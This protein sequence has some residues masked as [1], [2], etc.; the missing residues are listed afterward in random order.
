[1]AKSNS[2]KKKTPKRVLALPDLEHATTAAPRVLR[3]YAMLAVLIGRGLRR[4]ELLA[5]QL[6]AIQQREDHWVIA[7]L[8]GKAGHIRTVPIPTWVKTT[9]DAWTT[10]ADISEGTVF[11]AI[12]KTGRVWGT[13]MTAKVLWDVVR[14]G[15]AR[16][17]PVSVRAR[18]DSNDRTL[19]RM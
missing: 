3:D 13:G 4:G 5:L 1:M 14:A 9:I 12:N 18:V 15:A 8:V 17:D 16:P 7:D 10:A 6:G 2:R 11:R 19:P